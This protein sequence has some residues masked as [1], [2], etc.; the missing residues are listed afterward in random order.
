MKSI[1]I[2]CCYFGTLRPDFNLWLRTCSYND[3]IS[4]IIF[5]DQTI[6]T[7]PQNVTIVISSLKELKHR[8]EEK[9][10][11]EISLET[12]YKLCDYKPAYGFLFHD[13]LKNFDYWGYCDFDMLFGDLRNNLDEALKNSYDKILQFGHLSLY[14]NN[15]INNSRFKLEGELLNFKEVFT[16]PKSYVFDELIGIYSFFRNNNYSMYVSNNIIDISTLSKRFIR[17]TDSDSFLQYK[18]DNY[19][20]QI[21]SWENGKVYHIYLEKDKIVKREQIYIHMSGRKFP[22]SD[23]ILQ[24]NSIYITPDGYVENIEKYLSVDKIKHM[25][26]TKNYVIEKLEIKFNDIN[27]KIRRKLKRTH[28][29]KKLRKALRH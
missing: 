1:C 7:I 20:Y 14:K 23:S 11:F 17:T 8:F 15:D 13:Y 24:A 9:L 16:S 26:T 28:S 22:I 3:T 5:T 10:K 21:F 29:S 19:K 4:W 12:P 18:T 6:D 2:I 25:N 27:R